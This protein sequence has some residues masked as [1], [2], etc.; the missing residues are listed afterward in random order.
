MPVVSN[1]S[2]ILNLAIIG[3]LSLL[4][5]QFETIWIPSA[6]IDELRIQEELP[7]CSEIR[8]AIEEGW[9]TVIDV[10]DKDK[11]KLLNRDLD[12]GESE[13]ITLALQ[14]NAEWILVDEREARKICKSIGLNVTGVL[15]IILKAWRN[16]KLSSLQEVLDELI[17]KAGFRISNILYAN[18]LAEGIEREN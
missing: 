11:V 13:A 12:R 14:V 18:I 8:K 3:K 17:D 9:L 16:G 4:H 1:T 2:P 15:G 7:G 6:V 5:E 10:K